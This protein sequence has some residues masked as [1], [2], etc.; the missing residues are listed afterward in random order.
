MPATPQLIV[1]LPH[2]LQ[3]LTDILNQLLNAPLLRF[4]ER[5]HSQMPDK[6][7][8]YAIY[9]MDLPEPTVIRAGRTKKAV[10]GLRQRVYRNQYQGDQDGN[11]RAQLVRSGVCSDTEV[12]KTWI[13]RNAAVRFS[14][15][16]DDQ[17]RKWAEYFML[18]LLR[19]EY[20]D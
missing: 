14:A 1:P 12:A 19:P 10:G 5:L 6:H 11:L 9:R 15:I 13:Q 2:R 3:E 7:G 17:L 8:I 20:C 16:E 4:D 18:S